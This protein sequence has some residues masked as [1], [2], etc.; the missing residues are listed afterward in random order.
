MTKS[1][2]DILISDVERSLH[3][4]LRKSKGRDPLDDAAVIWLLDPRAD[5]L[6]EAS[7][8]T[9]AAL[10]K[11]RDYRLIAV[12]GFASSLEVLGAAERAVLSESLERLADR[13]PVVN[14][15]IMGFCADP[16][17]L[18]GIALGARTT[19]GETLARVQHWASRFVSGE[20][21][22]GL[23][24]WQVSVMAGAAQVLG[25]PV[26]EGA[27]TG[28]SAIVR[29]ALA[30]RGIF[31][32]T[33]A[34]AGEL[35]AL[36]CLRQMGPLESAPRA[37]LALACL[38]QIRASRPVISLNDW[39]A[40]DVAALLR[41]TE[42]AFQQWTWEDEPR[43]AGGHARKWYIDHEYHVQNVLWSMLSPI[44]ADLVPEETNLEN[45]GQKK[46]RA[47]LGIP[48]L[49]LLIE[50]KFMRKAMT[51]GKMIEQIG[52]D[53]SLYFANTAKYDSVI[54][55]VWDE[56]RRVEQHHMMEAGLQKL[57]R[58]AAAVVVSRPAALGPGS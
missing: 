52:A 38:R 54:A 35:E 9:A 53:T 30:S 20:L 32:A 14:G 56:A 15:N 24:P 19:G 21:A 5:T 17:A 48:C 39:T 1:L 55:F 51:P 36:I 4:E 6:S 25:C 3:R 44:F 16:V 10:A 8:E 40:S 27:V 58:I 31:P 26:K 22:P 33:H 50:V 43:V 7:A 11:S 41:R 12:L 18:L 42:A 37:A 47:D 13:E 2:D 49:R 34:S 23:E 45:V 46:P 29:V 28:E 57:A